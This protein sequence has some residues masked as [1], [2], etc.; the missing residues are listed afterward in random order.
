MVQ[1]TVESLARKMFIS[2]RLSDRLAEVAHRLEV[3]VHRRQDD[4]DGPGLLGDDGD[5]ATD[6]V[7]RLADGHQVEDHPHEA[8]RGS[9]DDEGGDHDGDPGDGWHV[10]LLSPAAWRR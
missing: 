4:R 5:P 6:G 10:D 2:A 9:G 7:E 3:R 8:E 1:L